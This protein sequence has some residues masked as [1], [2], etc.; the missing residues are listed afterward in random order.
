MRIDQ[1]NLGSVRYLIFGGEA[2]QPDKLE[3]FH[4]RYPQTKIVN[5]YGITET[6]VHV[7]YREIGDREIRR[8]I[9]DI[10]SAIPTLGV[11]I[12]NGNQMCG[13]GVPG[14]LCVTGA[15]VAKGYLNRP[16]L[17]AEKFVP[18]PFGEGRM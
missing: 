14:E 2:L 17:T 3:R 10:G 4:N 16:E 9:S 8:G 6:T 7:T 13:I 5:M 11:F 18:N 12:M 15:G 1:G